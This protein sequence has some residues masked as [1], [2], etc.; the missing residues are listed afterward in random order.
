[1]HQFA[2]VVVGKGNAALCAALSARDRGVSVA[3]LEAATVEESG[4]NSRFAGGVMRFA[5]STVEE[6]QQL[7]D[8]SRDEAR[9][10]DWDSNSVEEFYEDLYRVTSFR[11]DPD[12]SEA[13][14]TKSFEG[15]VWLRSQGASFVPNYG[16]QSAIV[17][18]KRK[19][20]GRFPLTMNGGGAGLVAD[21]TRTAEKKGIE[22]FYET[23]AVSLIYDGER[24][25]G[26]RAKQRGKLVEFHASAVVLACGGFESNPEWRTRYLGPG[27]ELA[28]VRGTRHN[29][30][31]GLRMAL[32]IGACPC[33]NWSG[34]HA[35]S[36]ERHAPE[37]GVVERSHD[38]YRHSY[39][40]S[41]MI[42]AEGRRFVDEGA[43][44]YNYTYA[45][46]GAEVL[47][48]AGQY[49][50]QVF[51]AKTKPLLKKEYGG[52]NVTRFIGNTL[53]ELADRLEGVD[54]KM[55]LTTV[56]EY[57]AAVRTD[58]P[59]NHAV[60]DGR[61]TVG[62][63]PPKSN[64]ANV[65]DTPPFEAYGV[66]C[67][68]TFTFG[69]LRI[70]HETGQVLDLGYEPIP[71]LYAAGEMVGGLFY[72]NYPA[73]T[74]LVSGLVFGRIAGNGAGAAVKAK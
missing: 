12:L 21:L 1:M 51:D 25:L 33:G 57:N 27:W 23:R 5:Y 73:G 16:A 4:G 32:E 24:V 30:G 54:P 69:G 45:K 65:L 43:D 19:F 40:L 36:W 3:M 26:V 28:K 6:L 39:P 71:G 13:L 49:A 56:R 66:T 68:I 18:G 37:F 53:E 9:N 2:V 10:T 59:F 29:L 74:G 42:N 20:F 70:N 38:P 58:V 50:Y 52:R 11:T 8:I 61:C 35:V 17:E 44:F 60:R 48:Q 64:W 34:R 15:M 47:K 63:D 62:I 55:F 72:F 67:G 14:I 46:Y 22:I 41:I 31:E 7:T